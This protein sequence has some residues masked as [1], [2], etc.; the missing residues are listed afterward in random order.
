MKL[1]H[2]LL[3]FLSFS[4]DGFVVMLIKGASLRELTLRKS[5]I[6]SLLCAAVSGLSV[7]V[8]YLLSVIFRELM[9]RRTEIL[10]ACMIVFALG[11]YIITRSFFSRKAEEKLDRDFNEIN[12]LRLAVRSS[13]PTLLIGSG[14]FLIGISLSIGVI[15]MMSITFICTLAALQVGYHQG[16]I[17]ARVVGISS[18][19]L[20]I[21]FSIYLL[22][23]YVIVPKF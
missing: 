11:I 9:I 23:I 19:A 12:C 18:G 8:G 10:T 20:M 1:I 15:T 4:L 5:I 16:P 2:V 14:C 22:N 3:L 7:I 6:Y 13:V 21:L 17:L